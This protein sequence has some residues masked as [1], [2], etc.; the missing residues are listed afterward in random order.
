MEL[1]LGYL[2]RG[3]KATT[4]SGFVNV[5]VQR[6]K[7]RLLDRRDYTLPIYHEV[8]QVQVFIFLIPLSSQRLKLLISFLLPRLQTLALFIRQLLE[9]WLDDV[10]GADAGSVGLRIG[11]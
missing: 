2:F 8:G 3:K 10:V 6:Y 11:H 1:N 4:Y 9:S 7:L 5:D